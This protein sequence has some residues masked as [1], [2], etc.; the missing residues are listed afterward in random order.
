M[1]YPPDGYTTIPVDTAPLQTK[2]IGI[3]GFGN[4]AKPWAMNLFDSGLEVYVGLRV[5]STKMLDVL[6]GLMEILP[7]TRVAKMCDIICLLIP[8]EFISVVLE[9]DVFP[10]IKEGGT[11]VLAHSYAL[12]AGDVELPANVDCIL[13]AP[14]GPGETVRENFKNGIGLPAQWDVI[15]D[16]TGDAEPT[17]HALASGL[18]F[19][20]GGLRRID[21]RKEA[22]IDLFSEQAVL[23]GGLLAIICE[24]LKVLKNA[25][26]DTSVSR[27]SC[28]DE[29]LGTAKLFAEEGLQGGLDKV[30]TVA[31]FGA[32]KAIKKI[33]EPLAA[34]FRELLA[35]IE[36]GVFSEDFR[37]A[38][39]KG[40]GAIEELR[41][42][43]RRFDG[44]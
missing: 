28:I 2:K 6:R 19:A 8:D 43:L 25:G 22:I 10:N 32:S 36:S 9:E 13:L 11:I 42:N 31:A 17:A 40:S 23:V 14:H 38:S 21:Y 29:I 24:A 7:P 1:K 26:Y 33:A 44:D 4:Q 5:G 30:S 16:F 41:E 12:Y 15:Q 37:D 39:E 3:I 18:G 20:N 35:E 27:V 34:G